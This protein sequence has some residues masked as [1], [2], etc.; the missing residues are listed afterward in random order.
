MFGTKSVIGWTPDVNSQ[1]CR[2]HCGITTTNLHCVILLLRFETLVSSRSRFF[3]P[4]LGRKCTSWGFFI[5]SRYILAIF[6]ENVPVRC[7]IFSPGPFRPFLAKMYRL[8]VFYSQPVHFGHLGRKH[9]HGVF[10]YSQPVHF[11]HFLAKMY[12]LG[13]LYS[14]PVHFG[15]FLAKMYQLGVLYSQLV[16]FGHFGGKFSGWGHFILSRSILAILSES[17]PDWGFL[18]SAGTFWP[19]CAKLYRLGVFLFS[20][21]TFC[22]FWAKMYRRGFFFSR[23]VHVGFF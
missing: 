16:H 5:L 2:R 12:Q 21:R 13:V 4:N 7:F 14:Q 3:V 19:F 6:G 9:T 18:F 23:P 17:V 20:S 15:Q 11:G 10:F 22:P 8:G 1:S